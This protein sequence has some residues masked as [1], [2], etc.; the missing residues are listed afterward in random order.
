[1]EKKQ[2]SIEQVF[3][4]IKASRNDIQYWNDSMLVDWLLEQEDRLKAMHKEEMKESY[5][6]GRSDQQSQEAF[7]HRNAE[8]YYNET[9]GGK[10]IQSNGTNHL[11][12]INPLT[13]KL[14]NG[15]DN[16]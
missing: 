15:G 6:E 2:S 11:S 5:R 13:D 12:Y 3:S 16:E 14:T 1:M 4:H 7:Y 10:S 8:Q 9:F